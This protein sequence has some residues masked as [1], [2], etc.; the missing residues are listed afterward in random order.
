M[1]TFIIHKAES[2]GH[3]QHG[4][5]DSH[6]T[7]SFANYYDPER[8]HFGALRV[9]NDDIVEGGMGFGKHPHENMEIISIPL[10]GT[11]EHKDSMGSASRIHTGDVQVMS[12]GTGVFHS[13]YNPDRTQKV[14]F[15][16]I[17]LLPNE[18]NVTPRYDQ[19]SYDRSER[20]NRF[21]QIV[22]PDYDKE[23]LSVH[24]DAW[25][26]M[27]SLTPGFET[28]YTVKKNTNGVYVFVMEG[29]VSINEKALNRRDGIGISGTDSI[30]I[31]SGSGAEL[32]VMDV[33]ML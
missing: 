13:E 11:L 24:Q 28:T 19:K 27:I 16:Q 10:S 32:L 33:P 22:S 1:E 5:L 26:S 12:A 3:A 23:G 4:W 25:F 20:I 18:Q 17:W 30:S 9:L 21:Q 8:V 29:E 6:H 7:F 15:L 31:R 2:R 14:N